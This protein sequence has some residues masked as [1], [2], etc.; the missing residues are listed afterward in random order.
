MN[1]VIGMTG[2]LLDT[3]L[4]PVQRDYAETVAEDNVVNQRAVA[5]PS[6]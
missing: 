2:M 1:G 4:D 5:P 6:R 3:D